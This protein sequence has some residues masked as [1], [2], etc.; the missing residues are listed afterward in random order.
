MN[1]A[2]IQLGV[3]NR[4]VNNWIRNLRSHFWNFIVDPLSIEI[5]RINKEL[6]GNLT[7]TS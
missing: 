3:T 5:E 1:N 6:K 7:R 2:W 4:E